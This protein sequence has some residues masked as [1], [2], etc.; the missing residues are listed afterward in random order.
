VSPSS[1]ATS[2]VSTSSVAAAAAVQQLTPRATTQRGGETEHSLWDDLASAIDHLDSDRPPPPPVMVTRRAKV[3]IFSLLPHCYHH[4][5]H[6]D[7]DEL[8]LNLW[9][10]AATIPRCQR[11]WRLLGFPSPARPSAV[12]AVV[13]LP[14]P[15]RQLAMAASSNALPSS[16]SSIAISESDPFGSLFSSANVSSHEPQHRRHLEQQQQKQPLGLGG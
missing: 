13:A 3:L 14:S 4:H 12:H 7:N 8:E 9:D 5:K 11:R 1:S 6:H 10:P 16:A 15:L 2:T